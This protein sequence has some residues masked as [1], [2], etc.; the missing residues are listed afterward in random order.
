MRHH[1]AR[2]LRWPARVAPLCLAITLW[3]FG[4]PA[5]SLALLAV[6]LICL[7]G[8]LHRPEIAPRDPADSLTLAREAAR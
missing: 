4:Y 5:L 7:V 1:P 2:I 8:D 6:A 3:L